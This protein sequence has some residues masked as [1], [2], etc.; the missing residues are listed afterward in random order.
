[1]SEAAVQVRA[2]ESAGG[3]S[4]ADRP[5]VV[6]VAGNPNSGKTT[7]FNGLTGLRAQTANFPGTT[8]ELKVADLRLGEALL[9]LLDLPG[10]YSLTPATPE[11]R[12]ATDLVLGRG[13]GHSAP[14]GLLVV[15]DA[16]NLARSLFLVSQILEQNLPVVVALTMSDAADR[17]GIHV[18]AEGLARELGCPVIPV[19]AHTGTG[20]DALRGALGAM[21]SGVLP[22]RIVLAQPTG[23]FCNGCSSCPFQARYAWTDGMVA[24]CVRMPA[25]AKSR[26]TERIDRVLTHRVAGLAAFLGVMLTVFY[27]IFSVATVPMDLIDGLFAH[28]GSWVAAHVPPGE[29]RSLLVDGVIGGVGGILVF[30]PQICILFFFLALLEDS[31]YLARAAFVMD[32]LMRRIGLP[33]TAFVPLLSAHACAIPAIMA[34]RVI[35]DPRDRLVTILVAPL[36]TCSARIPVYAM[37][38]ALLFPAQPVLASLTFV[39][40]YALGITAALLAALVLKKTILPGDSK[41]LVLELPSYRVPHLRNALLYTYDRARVFVQ[42]AG[43]VI[44]AIS[45]ILWALATYPRYPESTPPDTTRIQDETRIA[46]TAPL[47]P[48]ADAIH[49]QL[50]LAHS[51]AGRLGHLIEPIVRP[52]GYDWQ[53][54]IGIISSF[55]AREVIV[56]TLAIVYGIGADTPDENHEGLQATLRRAQ[57]A[58]G[59]P[60]FTTATSFSLLVFYVLAMQCLP[61]QAVTKRETG[62]WKWA[63]FQLSYMSALAY[64]AAFITYQGLQLLGVS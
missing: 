22:E 1:M 35:R 25:V 61:T 46:A 14:D 53:I 36:M 54:G 23:S 58:D 32:R 6:A 5:F 39:G 4:R 30:L 28:A 24:R 27:L 57:R 26:R 10:M 15:A 31:G 59:S 7:L 9:R 2:R 42:Q 64:I 48:D 11:E 17:H 12:M 29:L 18:D 63:L 47:Q 56:S 40:A 44:L 16:D 21:A 41:P 38:T 8:V 45:I 13:P 43:T 3:R 60:V 33:G 51:F 19:V 52:L 20:M 34:T 62:S 49:A 50:A 55:A 37:I